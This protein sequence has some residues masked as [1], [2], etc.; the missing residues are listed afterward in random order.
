MCEKERAKRPKKIHRK[1]RKKF[2]LPNQ[3]ELAPL[4]RFE[5]KKRGYFLLEQTKQTK[6]STFLC[7]ERDWETR[8]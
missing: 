6:Q 3:D 5:A 4:F 2:F 1:L 7:E 8:K